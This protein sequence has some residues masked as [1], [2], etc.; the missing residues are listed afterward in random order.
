MLYRENN[1]KFVLGSS[2]ARRLNLLKQINITPD[3]VF[4]PKIDEY[5]KKKELPIIYAKRMA[6]EKMVIVKEKFPND[7]ILT[8]D[9]VVYAGKRIIDKTDNKTEALHFL[10][11]LSG[12]RHRVSTA[13]N[14]F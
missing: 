11:I 2:S 14:I 5:I 10:K 7:L 8:A 4:S 3:K 9:T 6:T 1:I 12:R 13:F